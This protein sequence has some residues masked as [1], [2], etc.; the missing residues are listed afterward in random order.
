MV[1]IEKRAGTIEMVV[2]DD[3]VGFDTS[4]KQAEHSYGLLGIQERIY[5]MKGDFHIHSPVFRQRNQDQCKAYRFPDYIFSLSSSQRISFRRS[6]V[7]AC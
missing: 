6:V 5:M 4:I 7:Q 1:N 2:Q 3:G